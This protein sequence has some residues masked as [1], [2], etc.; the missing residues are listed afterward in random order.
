MTE[1]RADQHQVPAAL[2]PVD[3]EDVPSEVGRPEHVG[4]QHG[5]EDVDGHR[6]Q[7]TVG[8]HPGRVDHGVEPA[9]PLQG[10]SHGTG[11]GSV[12][13]D[14]GGLDARTGGAELLALL[15][16]LVESLSVSGHEHQV[17][18]GTGGAQSDR[19]ADAARRA[20]HHQDGRGSV[21]GLSTTFTQPSFFCWN[22]A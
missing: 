8:H 16:H 1:D 20:R 11:H 4:P 22:I 14:V 5:V 17:G 19:A 3:R 21:H 13:P 6:R 18:A 2:R 15:R 12:V 10:A 9:L 7:R